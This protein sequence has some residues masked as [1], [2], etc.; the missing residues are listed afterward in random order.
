LAFTRNPSTGTPATYQG[1]DKADD[2]FLV[3]QAKDVR[4]NGSGGDD[5]IAISASAL[6]ANALYNIESYGNDGDD[7]MFLSAALVSNS[8]VQGGKG[9][10]TIGAGA[11]GFQSSFSGS[12]VRG[13][14][15]NDTVI[16]QNANGGT[17]NGNKGED[18]ISVLGNAANA[19]IYGGSEADSITL[20]GVLYTNSTFNGSKGN[21]ILTVNS[22]TF[23]GSVI[24]GGSENDII[25]VN[26]GTTDAAGAAVAGT[27]T[28]INVS[29]DK[30]DD[31]MFVG[32]ATNRLSKATATGGEGKDTI[33]VAVTTSA[34]VDAGVGADTV[35]GATSAV[36]ANVT[37]VFNSGDSVAATA[38]TFTGT[39]LKD[40][41]IT[42]GNGV[43]V[44]EGM[45]AATDKVDVDFTDSAIT[46]LTVAALDTQLLAGQI[47]GITGTYAAGAF[48]AGAGGADALM[49]VGGGNNTL[50]NVFKASTDMFVTDG[51]IF[52]EENFV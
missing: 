51:F 2:L 15:D 29:G 38:N 34:T 23:S 52:V 16:V 24:Y 48:T 19:K 22:G 41:V 28:A 5:I 27:V 7:T 46:D 26:Q 8:I 31:Q 36:L 13:G 17:F 43:D 20:D 47:Y 39:T 10:D 1:S 40:A 33:N 50:N 18:T 49:I 4:V 21:D 42:F 3:D 9:K 30:G 37:T 25:N 14:A 45:Q 12:I 6:A 35:D 32:R 44:L 11:E